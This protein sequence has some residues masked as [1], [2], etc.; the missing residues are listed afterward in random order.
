MDCTIFDVVTL[1]GGDIEIRVDTL[2]HPLKG[3]NSAL[4]RATSH[5][6]HSGTKMPSQ[7]R[8]AS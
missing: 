6:L 3:S 2:R 4:A 7:C 5:V 1:T 8:V